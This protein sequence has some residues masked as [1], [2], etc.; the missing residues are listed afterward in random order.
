[1][2]Y[3]FHIYFVQDCRYKTVNA[4]SR[5]VPLEANWDVPLDGVAFLR[6]D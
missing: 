4:W 1:M 2:G 3:K 6:L 5:G